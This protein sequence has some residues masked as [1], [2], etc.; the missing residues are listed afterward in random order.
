[1]SPAQFVPRNHCSFW[2]RPL[3][4]PLMIHILYTHT[5]RSGHS[6]TEGLLSMEWGGTRLRG[7]PR[8]YADSPDPT[9]TAALSSPFVPSKTPCDRKP[10]RIPFERPDQ[11]IC[12]TQN[13]VWPFPFTSGLVFI[14]QAFLWHGK[15]VWS[16]N[17]EK[18]FLSEE[19]RTKGKEK[20]TIPIK[21]Q[22]VPTVRKG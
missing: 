10:L 4:F 7:E 2:L 19:F 9:F 3:K 20:E 6:H 5:F 21:Q 17:H 13:K 18:H 22:N 16:V 12:C 1:M 14:S 15:E 11:N 8:S